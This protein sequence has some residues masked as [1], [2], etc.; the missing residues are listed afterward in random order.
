MKLT[1]TKFMR[2]LLLLLVG[3]SGLI[4]F[5]TSFS[6]LAYI[7]AS[8]D[9]DNYFLALSIPQLVL[10]LF[11]FPIN[12]MLL[13]CIVKG[14]KRAEALHTA[15]MFVVFL[16]SIFIM[17]MLYLLFK[18]FFSVEYSEI[19]LLLLLA[20]PALVM[21]SSLSVYL[22]AK[23]KFLLIEGASLLSNAIGLLFIMS[24]RKMLSVEDIILIYI[25]K[26]WLL[27][28]LLLTFVRFSL[29]R[30]R[31]F[32][33]IFSIILKSKTLI[34][35]SSITKF[36][37]LI[38]RFLLSFITDGFLSLYYITQQILSF[39][40]QFVNKCHTATIVPSV[41]GCLRGRVNISQ[42]VNILH[43]SKKTMVY[44]FF[45]FCFLLTF[46]FFI[47]YLG[48]SIKKISSENINEII[49]ISI[50]LSGNLLFSL[51][52]DF[53]YTAFYALG[54]PKYQSRIDINAFLVFTPLKVV[55]VNLF[56][57]YIFIL[58]VSL[59]ATFKYFASRNYLRKAVINA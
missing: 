35:T 45:F 26:G 38:E 7:G 15:Y 52:R 22:Y 30:R 53:V 25:F 19:Y 49:I 12:G 37:P 10:A 40:T 4:Q 31:H 17:I 41:T 8:S 46:F 27:V 14:K 29:P 43:E 48:F 54:L 20:I 58:L 56:G 3:G 47:S 42:Y 44:L 36:E 51:P 59:Q 9:L 6:L 57:I 23:E 5:A 32:L 55:L 33:Y 24:L 34:F 11:I 13:P 21:S 18:L 16:F 39:V 1:I 2:I 28:L 50:L